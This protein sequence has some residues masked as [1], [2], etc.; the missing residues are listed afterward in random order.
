MQFLFCKLNHVISNIT[1]AISIL[2]IYL[3]A[4]IVRIKKRRMEALDFSLETST[5]MVM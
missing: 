4:P 5:S 1:R 3:F 2:I